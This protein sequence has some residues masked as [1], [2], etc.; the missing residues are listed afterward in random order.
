MNLNKLLYTDIL[1]TPF[2]QLQRSLAAQ[3]ALIKSGLS[4]PDFSAV[5]TPPSTG[6]FQDI[7]KLVAVEKSITSGLANT[8]SAL[9]TA[10]NRIL[11]EVHT[12]AATKNTLTK[13]FLQIN[14]TAS[15][16]QKVFAGSVLPNI[17][18]MLV[19]RESLASQIRSHLQSI[20]K[21]NTLISKDVLSSI[22]SVIA[23]KDLLSQQLQHTIRETSTLRTQ[24]VPTLQTAVNRLSSLRMDELGRM[25]EELEARD[26]LFVA[27]STEGS[28]SL[29]DQLEED[30]ASHSE[31]GEWSIEEQINYLIDWTVRQDNAKFKNYMFAFLIGLIS[32]FICTLGVEV[33]PSLVSDAIETRPQTI[34]RVVRERIQEQ[35]L[36]SEDFEQL[37]I[38]SRPIA[39]VRAFRRRRSLKIAM[40][41]AGDVVSVCEK[42]GK[43]VFVEWTDF[44]SGQGCDGWML[45][46]HLTRVKRKRSTRKN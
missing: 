29:A 45:S 19:A 1:N 36:P 7:Q 6:V 10:Q 14:K 9:L 11:A 32:S 28:T 22:R 43:W 18:S 42:R 3:Q 44:E 21:V 25:A 35:P 15:V 20:N 26:S 4:I 5:L 41:N 40:L 46:K 24:V 16:F 30:I 8:S 38:V 33:I 39:P 17:R 2:M 12:I 34:I 13:E 31:A 27:W 37:R 23:V